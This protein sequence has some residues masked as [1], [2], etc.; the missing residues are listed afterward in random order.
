M[1]T[2]VIVD[3]HLAFRV[4]ARAL[5]EAEGFTVIAEA[6]DGTSGL[7]VARSLRPDIVLLDIGLPDLPGFD[8]ARELSVDG[9]PPYVVLTSS[10]DAS[11]YGPRLAQS[12][13][14]GFIAK[15]DISGAAMRAFLE[16]R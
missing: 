11:N 6:V 9:P 1:H 4:Q 8:V 10:R 2:I 7:R 16:P 3:D 14:A 12:G 5:L 15:D 13:A